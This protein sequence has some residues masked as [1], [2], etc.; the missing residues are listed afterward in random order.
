MKKT[1]KRFPVTACVLLA[2][3]L[4]LNAEEAGVTASINAARIG[5]DDTLVYTLTFRNIANPVQPDLSFWEDFKTLRTTR[6]SEYQ[7]SNGISTSITSFT[8]Y[9]MPVRTGKLTLPP[10]HYRHE[11]RA[12]QTQELAIEVVTG[13]IFPAA[14]PRAGVQDELFSSPFRDPPQ[15]I[16]IHLQASLSKT[17]CFQGEQLLFRVLLYTRNR[18]EAVDM[19]SSPSFAGFWQEWFPVPRAIRA[20]S[21]RVG[22]IMYQ[23]YEIRKAAL[24]ANE[25][26]TLT[27]PPL[28]FEMQVA[29]SPGIFSA[30]RPVHRSTQAI[31]VHAREL[32]PEAAGLPVGQFSFAVSCQ[33]TRAE[34]N[35]IITL[36]MEIRGSGNS[37]TII[38]PVLQG[39]DVF[40]VYPAK[41]TQENSYDALSLIGAARF[42]IPVSFQQAGDITFPSLEFTYFDPAKGSLVNLRS[43]PLQLR[44]GGEKKPRQKSPISGQSAIVPEGE[45]IDFIKSGPIRD[46]S[47]YIHDQGWFAATI[48][49]LFAINLAFLLKISLWRRW[50]LGSPLLKNRRLLKLTLGR[51]SRIGQYEEIAAILEHYCQAKTGLGLAEINDRRIAEWLRRRQVPAERIDRF[52]FIKNQAELAKFSPL[53]KTQAEMKSDLHALRSLL[54]QMDKKL[55]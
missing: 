52:L 14:D 15:T 26:G 28:R 10:V 48:I 51:L 35:E 42:E 47:R 18:I 7:F 36:L 38:P 2:A 12:Y 25:S 20:G 24:F 17:D 4:L 54:K 5:L 13:S 40:Q 34:L 31:Q 27:I 46:Q 11:G 32:P 45:D 8:Y 1:G 9:L 30:S 19:T 16:D 6:S 3:A 22:G 55:K 33:Q 53:K 37:K 43:Q 39:S 44:V 41:V 49:A 21:E 50:V 23:V 29:D